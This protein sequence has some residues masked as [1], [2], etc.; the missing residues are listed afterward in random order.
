M[1]KGDI[2]THLKV[3]IFPGI[4]AREIWINFG[5]ANFLKFQIDMQIVNRICHQ[6]IRVNSNNDY[7]LKEQNALYM[8]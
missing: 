2:R 7:N 5:Q 6:T 4:S 8:F 1:N 3:K